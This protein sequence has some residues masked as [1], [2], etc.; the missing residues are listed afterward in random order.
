MQGRETTP[1]DDFGFI[2]RS[3]PCFLEVPEETRS[4]RVNCFHLSGTLHIHSNRFSRLPR[5]R[6]ES[7]VKTV[8]RN[9]LVRIEISGKIYRMSATPIED[10]ERRQ[11]I[12]HGRGYWYAWDGIRIFSFAPHPPV[13]RL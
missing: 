7:W 1:P 10:E 4:I 12:L 3:A 8:R 5:W 11:A 6:G 2:G 9:P 13:D